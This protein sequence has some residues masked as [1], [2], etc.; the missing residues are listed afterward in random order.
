LYLKIRIMPHHLYKV[1]DN[2]LV[3]DLPLAP[4][5]AALGAKVR[6]PTLDGAVEMN[7]PAGIRSGKKLRVR[8]RGLGSGGKKGDQLVRIVIATP[9]DLTDRERE[10]WQQL[11]EESSFEP[12]PY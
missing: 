11:A 9:S 3:L 2:N 1:S 7:I 6:V 10:L 12:R 5:E 4:W 8:G